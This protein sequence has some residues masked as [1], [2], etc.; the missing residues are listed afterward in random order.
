[1]LG[2]EASPGTV[3][4][5]VVGDVALP[6]VTEVPMG[7]PLADQLGTPLTYAHFE[8]AGS[9]LGAAGFIVYDDSACMVEVA[10]MVSRFLVPSPMQRR[11]RT[12]VR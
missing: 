11:T 7:T 6:R 5:T 12:L 3:I 8:A 1:M 2:T 10:A 9:G 4:C